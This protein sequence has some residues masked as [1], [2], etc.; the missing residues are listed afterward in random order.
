MHFE[1][2]IPTDIL[3]VVFEKLGDDIPSSSK[4]SYI[5]LML[6]WY[7]VAQHHI[8]RNIEFPNTFV[9]TKGARQP[10]LAALVK[11]ASWTEA[12]PNVALHSA[13]APNG[14][15][16]HFFNIATNIVDLSIVTIG[17]EPPVVFPALPALEY[18]SYNGCGSLSAFLANFPKLHHSKNLQKL[19]L[20]GYINLPQDQLFLNDMPSCLGLRTLLITGHVH[21]PTL[22]KVLF[23][24]SIGFLRSLNVKVTPRLWYELVAFVT[25]LKDTLQYLVITVDND[26]TVN[27]PTSS[28]T[29]LPFLPHLR[30]FTLDLPS[31]WS[32]FSYHEVAPYLFRQEQAEKIH[33]YNLR[34]ESAGEEHDESSLLR[35]RSFSFT[36]RGIDPEFVARM[37]LCCTNLEYVEMAYSIENAEMVA[38]YNQLIEA[39]SQSSLAVHLNIGLTFSYAV[40]E[41]DQQQIIHAFYTSTSWGN[42]Q[43]VTF[44]FVDCAPLSARFIYPELVKLFSFKGKG[45][46]EHLDI[47]LSHIVHPL[48]Y[49]NH[50]D[51]PTVCILNFLVTLCD[52]LSDHD[53]LPKLLQFSLSFQVSG[54][55]AD[56]RDALE[57]AI[58][59]AA[60]LEKVLEQRSARL[61]LKLGSS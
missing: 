8:F 11:V 45:S 3:D 48:E 36:S 60:R 7:S 32:Q 15:V 13:F 2:H 53:N 34:L 6:R 30:M 1:S 58:A 21:L 39:L 49:Y 59:A 54:A 22:S 57:E 43:R 33:V 61:Q 4:A 20:A 29:S 56:E 14:F 23:G 17:E 31:Q 55:Q 41:P 35:L 18:L 38:K 19:V 47:R 52:L 28:K 27:P 24:T 46:L 42:F 12:S 44:Y 40:Y 5:D 10:A 9:L 26:W 16:Q 37:L 25:V 50:A 51:S